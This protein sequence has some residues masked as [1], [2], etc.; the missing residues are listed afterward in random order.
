MTDK[1]KEYQAFQEMLEEYE[2]SKNYTPDYV[3]DDLGI[4]DE[5]DRDYYRKNPDDIYD[6]I[7]SN[8]EVWNPSEDVM[9]DDDDEQRER[10]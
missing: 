1:E 9:G 10:Y 3:L 8:G 5:A 2:R 7:L 4:T 6:V